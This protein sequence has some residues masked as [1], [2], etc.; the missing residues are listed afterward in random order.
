MPETTITWAKFKEAEILL[1]MGPPHIFSDAEGNLQL[2]WHLPG[3]S[4][5]PP[6][7]GWVHVPETCAQ[8]HGKCAFGEI[9]SGTV[10]LVFKLISALR[11]TRNCRSIEV[12]DKGEVTWECEKCKDI[13]SILVEDQPAEVQVTNRPGG[14]GG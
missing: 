2:H 14:S 10:G 7:E 11:H 3:G 5:M 8:W 12:D 13:L 9:L 6:P 1:Q 4:Y